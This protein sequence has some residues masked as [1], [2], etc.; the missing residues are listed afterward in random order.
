MVQKAAPSPAATPESEFEK[1][2]VHQT[3]P[4]ADKPDTA[5]EKT[6]VHQ[7][8]PAV[9]KKSDD[10]FEKTVVHK[11]K[12]SDKAAPNSGGTAPDVEI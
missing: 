12:D 8:T 6:V 7:A 3:V 11:I 4:A 1:T 5:F 10:E 9:T 2:L